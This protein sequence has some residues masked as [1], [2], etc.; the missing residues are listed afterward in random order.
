MFL[1]TQLA[2]GRRMEKY[3]LRRLLVLRLGVAGD[4]FQFHKL[5]L[6]ACRI[7]LCGLLLILVCSQMVN[8]DGP[9][10]ISNR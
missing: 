2:F 9:F 7:L 3:R 10:R 1:Q 8:Y 5:T 4:H 6:R